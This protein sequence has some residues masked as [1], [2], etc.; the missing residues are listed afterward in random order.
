MEY[1]FGNRRVEMGGKYLTELRDSNDIMEDMAALRARMKEEGYLLLRGFHNRDDVLQVRQDIL[2]KLAAEPDRLDSSFPQEEGIVGPKPRTAL[3]GGTN[4]D[5]PSLLKVANSPKL[6]AFFES[7]LGGEVRTYDYKWPR[8]MPTG[9]SSGCHYDNVYMG[10]GTPNVYTVWTPL[11]DVPKELGSLA[12]CLGSQHFD[13]VKDVYGSLDVD[14]DNTAGGILTEDP[15]EI[16]D[17]FGG[18]WATTDFQAGDIII[19]GMF[20]LHFALKNS[21][22][23]YRTSM[24]TRYQLMSEPIDERWVGSNPIGHYARKNNEIKASLQSYREKLGLSE[25][26]TK[27]NP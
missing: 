20:I 25:Y 19:F 2:A 21:T 12:L 13:Q 22:N 10:R 27:T 6:M 11:G 24:D 26:E 18:R 14:K 1:L 17:N 8:A 15:V 4:E 7:F 3:F 16:V 23:R 9:K 5:M